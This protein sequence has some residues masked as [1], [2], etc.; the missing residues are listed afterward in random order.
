MIPS[1]LT[2]SL[3]NV[4]RVLKF[5]GSK[6]AAGVP[7]DGVDV[8]LK[9]PSSLHKKYLIYGKETTVFNK[10]FSGFFLRYMNTS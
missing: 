8:F 5:P 10:I 6:N 1:T 2:L 3:K 9:C 4:L 7:C